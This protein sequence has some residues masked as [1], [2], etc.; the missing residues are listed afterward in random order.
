MHKI[1]P[2][3]AIILLACNVF[4]SFGESKFVIE[5]KWIIEGTPGDTIKLNGTFIINSARQKV[6]G[7]D[8][9]LGAELVGKEDL[10]M[11]YSF[12]LD[13]PKVE[14]VA[15]AEILTFPDLNIFEDPILAPASMQGTEYTS[16]TSEM[17]DIIQPLINKNSTLKTI[18]NVVNWANNYVTYNKLLA[19]Q[20][21]T[22]KQVFSDREGVCVEY[23]HLTIAIFNSMGL[24]SRY[25]SGHVRSEEWQ[26][27]SWVEVYVDGTGW[28]PVD[29]TFGEVGLLDNSHIYVSYGKDQ[30]DVFDTITS[31]YKVSISSNTTIEEI[32]LRKRSGDVSVDLGFDKEK[33]TV[34]VDIQ[35]LNNQYE[36]VTY[37]IVTPNEVIGTIKETIVLSPNEKRHIEYDINKGVFKEGYVYTM[38]LS[39]MANDVHQDTDV[40]IEKSRQILSEQNAGQV[41]DAVKTN[42]CASFLSFLFALFFFAFA[43]LYNKME[44]K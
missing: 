22:A 25:V 30:T 36:F 14:V 40:I 32:Y 10:R 20:D 7:L 23:S 1:L 31:L 4:S 17:A 34:N 38:K 27:H 41:S 26:P 13:K 33:Y 35:N 3:L 21:K 9:P 29:S 16:Y 12:K 8:V 6:L 24:K 18:V 42:P 39:A 44:S 28:I 15:R 19:D 37:S 11:I 5:K 2:L 43:N